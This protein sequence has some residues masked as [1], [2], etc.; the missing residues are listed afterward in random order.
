MDLLGSAFHCLLITE[1]I[2]KTIKSKLFTMV[3]QSYLH[4]IWKSSEKQLCSFVALE[5][6][7]GFI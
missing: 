7:F 6:I 5:G 3:Q 2:E 4:L 1:S